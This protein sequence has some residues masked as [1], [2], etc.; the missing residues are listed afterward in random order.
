MPVDLVAEVIVEVLLEVYGDG[1]AHAAGHLLAAP[2]ALGADE[3]LMFAAECPVSGDTYTDHDDTHRNRSQNRTGS[4]RR[5][6]LTP[7]TTPW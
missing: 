6:F 3:D 2:A 7:P 4:P 5:V 1:L